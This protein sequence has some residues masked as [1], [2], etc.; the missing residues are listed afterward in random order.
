MKH[1]FKTLP[2]K[3]QNN[4][5]WAEA[6]HCLGEETQLHDQKISVWCEIL[7]YRLHGPYYFEYKVS[8]HNY[9]NMLITLLSLKVL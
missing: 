4:R 3:N 2:P 6:N 8:Q 9:L 7:A 1:I 5:Q